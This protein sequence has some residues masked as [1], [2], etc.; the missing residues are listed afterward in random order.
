MFQGPDATTQQVAKAQDLAC[1]EQEQ[2]AKTWRK[3]RQAAL[4]RRDKRRDSIAATMPKVKFWD[5][6]RANVEQRFLN[7]KKS[8]GRKDNAAKKRLLKY[9]G[10]AKAQLASKDA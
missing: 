9:K 5:R 6:P 1:T 7:K 4:G 8:K 3:N 10:H 2:S